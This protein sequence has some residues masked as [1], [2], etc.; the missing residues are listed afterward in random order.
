V[1]AEG[2]AVLGYIY[3]AIE[4]GSGE[5]TIEFLGVQA[6]AR[7]RGVGRRLLLTALNWLF[8]VKNVSEVG[9]T[10]SDEDTDARALYEGV[11]FGLKH[12]GLNLRRVW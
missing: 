8:Q 12:T 7:R 4:D 9:L 10:V 6:D 11:G 5:G 2:D 3:A 1:H